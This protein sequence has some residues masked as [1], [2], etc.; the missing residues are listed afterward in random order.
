MADAI[1][2]PAS[3][4]T[5]GRKIKKPLSIISKQ[6]AIAL[7]A[8]RYFTGEPCQNGH[9]AAR[10]VGSNNQCVACKAIGDS[11]YGSKR[12]LEK[13]EYDRAYRKA[14]PAKIIANR[15]SYAAANSEAIRIYNAAY[16]VA[17]A[18]KIRAYRAE[19][20]N[21]RNAQ[22]REW[23][24]ANAEHV[25][26]YKKV[27]D[28]NK[29]M[30]DLNYKLRINLRIR[31]ATAVRDGA[32]AGSA[33]RDLGCTIEELKVYLEAK[34]TSGMSWGNWGRMGWHIDHI[35]P[36]AAFDLTDE[37]QAKEACHYKN[38]QPLWRLDNITKGARLDWVPPECASIAA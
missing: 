15:Q 36:L 37:T 13:A 1:L 31:L 9:I 29:M 25:S 12:K 11:V 21:K 7:G 26:A 4:P 10:N 6:D 35:K 19:N 18:D 20:K 32:K 14:N 34:F 33:V 3:L 38:L 2:S 28:A 23:A 17:N 22:K 5:I 24:A 8:K 16:G 27:Y 30:N